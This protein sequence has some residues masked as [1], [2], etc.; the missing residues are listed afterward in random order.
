M[1]PKSGSTSLLFVSCCIQGCFDALLHKITSSPVAVSF[2][3]I[4]GVVEVSRSHCYFVAVIH[5]YASNSY[6]VRSLA[7]N[8]HVT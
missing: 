1:Q 3:T 2:M 7:P 8:G 4:V 5:I 6:T